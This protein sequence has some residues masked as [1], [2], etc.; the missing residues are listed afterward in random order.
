MVS[1]VRK[2]VLLGRL[3]TGRDYK[4]GLWGLAMLFLD[5]ASGHGYIDLVEIFWAVYVIH[6][7]FC[8]C[9]S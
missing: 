6:V 4:R 5:L 3:V 2:M 8:V 1:E 7:L 9:Y